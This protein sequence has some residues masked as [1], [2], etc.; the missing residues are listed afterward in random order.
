[1]SESIKDSLKKSIELKDELKYE[2]QVIW[3]HT[4]IKHEKVEQLI[5]A[6]E[7]VISFQERVRQQ[8]IK[9]KKIGG[10]TIS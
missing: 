8:E 10:V 7:Q 1:M 9:N 3:E 2:I 5:Y 4:G 6:Y